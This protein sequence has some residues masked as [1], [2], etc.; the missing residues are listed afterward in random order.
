LQ[1]LIV[2]FHHVFHFRPPPFSVLLLGVV[3]FGAHFSRSAFTPQGMLRSIRWLA[4]V[5]YDT[6]HAAIPFPSLNHSH[7]LLSE[8]HLCSHKGVFGQCTA[9][10]HQV[11]CCYVLCPS[12]PEHVLCTHIPLPP[13]S[14]STPTPRHRRCRWLLQ[15]CGPLQSP[16]HLRRKSPY[17]LD[18]IRSRPC[19]STQIKAC[20]LPTDS[21]ADVP[22]ACRCAHLQRSATAR[23]WPIALLKTLGCATCL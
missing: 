14:P 7:P 11:H 15:R 12:L 20:H 17:I 10:E 9:V 3:I 16:A 5:L 1:D 2:R 8:Q 19:Q 22:A 4:R 18:P 6:S 23:C 13:P 21:T